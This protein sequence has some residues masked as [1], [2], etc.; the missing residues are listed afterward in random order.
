MACAFRSPGKPSTTRSRLPCSCLV[1]A[2]RGISR[3]RKFTWRPKA[4][5]TPHMGAQAEAPDSKSCD[6]RGWGR[7]LLVSHNLFFPACIP[8]DISLAFC[9]P[10]PC[11]QRVGGCESPEDVRWESEIPLR[12]SWTANPD[13]GSEIHGI[14]DLRHSVG[15]DF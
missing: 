6:C 13:P 5:G 9:S 7:G 10:R 14:P 8:S 1:A 15:K 11:A 2:S 3:T 12:G 4:L